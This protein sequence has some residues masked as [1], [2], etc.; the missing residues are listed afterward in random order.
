M[1]SAVT[2]FPFNMFIKFGS[3]FTPFLA[4]TV[5]NVTILIG[6]S[7]YAHSILRE[8]LIAVKKK[9]YAENKQAF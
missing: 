2:L 5:C 8:K 1:G 3:G 6:P 4:K 7:I 9:V